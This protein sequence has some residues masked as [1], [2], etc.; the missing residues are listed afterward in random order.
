MS[1]LAALEIF[2]DKNIQHISI[3]PINHLQPLL[4]LKCLFLLSN[5]PSLF[6]IDIC[7]K[8]PIDQ[9]VLYLL[10]PVTQTDLPLNGADI[11]AEPSHYKVHLLLGQERPNYCS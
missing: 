4:L 10:Y 3:K 8:L 7:H 6:P 2:I 11:V 5:Y 1:H 9:L